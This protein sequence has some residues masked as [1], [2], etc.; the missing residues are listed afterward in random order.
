MQHQLTKAAAIGLVCILLVGCAAELVNESSLSPENQRL[1]R[2]A[3]DVEARGD[4]HTASALYARAAQNSDN[5]VEAQLRL[6]QA[7]L[8]AGDYAA[9]NAAFTKVLQSDSKNPDALL[10]LGTAQL[11]SGDTESSARTLAMAAPLVETSGAYNRLGT[12]LIMLGRLD[13]AREA[14]ERAK[15]LAPDD[16]DI[17]VNVALAQALA[18]RTDEAV[19]AMRAVTQSPLA[20]PRHRANL[21][22]VLGIAGRFDE[23]KAVTV[24]NMSDAQKRDLLARAKKVRDAPNPLAKAR[25][26]GLLTAA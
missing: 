10:G 14:F 25:A 20:Q 26:I 2:L 9:A 4:Y 3:G 11:K 16:L 8:K 5:A 15:S 18:G 24:P 6:G 22:M 13:P 17:T 7:Q 1:M 19:T 23:A 21:V 12:A